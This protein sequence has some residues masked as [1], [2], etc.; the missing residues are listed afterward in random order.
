MNKRL[1]GDIFSKNPTVLMVTF[2]MNDSGYYEYNGDN[3][4]LYTSVFP[5]KLD[6]A[7]K[8]YGAFIKF[9]KGSKVQAKAA[10]S[11]ISAEQA[12]ITLNKLARKRQE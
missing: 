3:C 9:K 10:S 1:D 5:Q 12:L 8:G 11:Y 4:L 6:G 2:G 7:G